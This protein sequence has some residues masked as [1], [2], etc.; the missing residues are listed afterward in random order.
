M[1]TERVE[2]VSPQPDGVLGRALASIQLCFTMLNAILGQCYLR[3]RRKLS[4]GCDEGVCLCGLHH[5][6][7]FIRHPRDG[8]NTSA[9]TCP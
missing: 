6:G 7:G 5:P 2:P 1:S 4:L 8:A 9:G 3:S